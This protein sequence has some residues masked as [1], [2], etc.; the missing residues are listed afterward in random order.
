MV[1]TRTQIRMMESWSTQGPFELDFSFDDASEAWNANK[2]REGASYVYI[3][4]EVLQNGSTCQK[5]TPCGERC[6]VH[7]TKCNKNI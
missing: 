3:C 5:K 2:K 1:E 6:R 7:R 4:G